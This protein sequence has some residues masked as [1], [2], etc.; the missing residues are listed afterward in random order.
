MAQHYV[1]FSIVALE[2]SKND[3][4]A[5]A[6]IAREKYFELLETFGW[7]Q[8]DYEKELLSVVDKEWATIH[9]EICLSN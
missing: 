3:L 2:D 7:S 9:R 8:E 1:P 4:C 5:D 6:F